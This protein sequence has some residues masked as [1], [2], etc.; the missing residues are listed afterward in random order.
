MSGSLK[1]DLYVYIFVFIFERVVRIKCQ[2][3]PADRSTHL[4][5]FAF[6]S[7]KVES[8]GVKMNLI[9]MAQPKYTAVVVVVTMYNVVETATKKSIYNV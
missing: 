3:T 1:Y 8:T 5:E 4:A 2:K 6:L 7:I 9:K